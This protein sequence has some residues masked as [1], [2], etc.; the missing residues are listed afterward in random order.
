MYYHYVFN[1]YKRQYILI[2]KDLVQFL[3]K[4][5]YEIASEKGFE[6]KSL[7][8]LADHVHVLVGHAA[9]MGSS[10]VMKLLKGISAR[11]FFKQF[12]TNRFVYR[13]LWGRSYYVEEVPASAVFKIINYIKHQTIGGEDKRLVKVPSEGGAKKE[14]RIY[15]QVPQGRHG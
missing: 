14:P 6:I 3:T 9:E 7:A 2:D 13:K 5:F 8:I 1:T 12:R 15:S 11:Y 10:N 4:T